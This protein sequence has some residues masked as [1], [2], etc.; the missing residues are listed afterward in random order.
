MPRLEFT[1]MESDYDQIVD[2]IQK[3]EAVPLIALNCGSPQ[4]PQEAANNAWRDL[5]LRMGFDSAT[6]EPTGNG[7]LSFTAEVAL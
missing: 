1:M 3:A 7:K 5:G 2:A 6:V 4:S